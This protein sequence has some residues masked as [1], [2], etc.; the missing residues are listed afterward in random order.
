[1]VKVSELQAAIASGKDYTVSVKNESGRMSYSWSFTKQ[2][3]MRADA[4]VLTD[5]KLGLTVAKLD[6]NSAINNLLTGKNKK[7]T[8]LIINFEHNGVLPVQASVKIDVGDL[9]IEK[10]TTVYLYYYNPETGKLDFLPY[11]AKGF[12]V[13]NDGY[14]TVDIVHCSDYVILPNKADASTRTGSLDQIALSPVKQ[15]LYTGGTKYSKGAIQVTMPSTFKLVKNLRDE[16]PG[17]AIGA[18]TITYKSSNTKI[19]T[20]NST[21]AITARSRGTAKITATVKLYSGLTKTFTTSVTVKEPSIKIT[22]STA[23]MKLG[24][25]YTFKAGVEGYD[26]NNIVWTT[27]KKGI[28]VINKKTGK[29]AANSKGIDYVEASIGG[30]TVKVKVVVK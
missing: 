27:T 19:A 4:N 12:Q 11:T 3:L 23:A 25:T 29:A 14:I 1:M 13:D 2:N 10:N 24:S 16:T 30:Q 9:G 21:G 8:G 26:E 18:V 5:V 7:Q 22:K 20:V 17:T 15:T 6:T 28:L